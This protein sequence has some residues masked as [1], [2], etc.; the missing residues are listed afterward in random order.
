MGLGFLFLGL[1]RVSS[2]R[3]YACNKLTGIIASHFVY[4][5]LG[6]TYA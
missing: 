6:S 3:S 4:I 5:P 1:G 2:Y